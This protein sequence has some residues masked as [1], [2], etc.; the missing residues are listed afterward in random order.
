MEKEIKPCAKCGS[1]D[2]MNDGRC[3]NCRQI[4]MKKYRDENQEEI[5][6]SK[7]EWNKLNK[8]KIKDQSKRRCL[9]WRK[10]NPEKAKELSDKYIKNNPHKVKISKRKWLDNN[11]VKHNISVS[12]WAKTHR[13]ARRTHW[14]NYKARKLKNGGIFT[15]QEIDNLMKIQQGKCVNCQCDISKKYHI[16]HIMPLSLGGRNDIKNLQLLCPHCNL[17]KGNKN[18]YEFPIIRPMTKINIHGV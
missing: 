15:K 13:I 17:V 18:P 12:L 8:E 10:L 5:K 1:T 4:Y 16:D 7:K 2:I 9:K 11:R 6:K 14:Q 3:R